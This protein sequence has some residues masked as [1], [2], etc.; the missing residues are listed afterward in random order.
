M[1]RD[2]LTYGA[3]RVHPVEWN[4][5]EVAGLLAAYCLEH[6]LLPRA[7][8]NQPHELVAFQAVLRREGIELAWPSLKPL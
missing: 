4:V 3:Y 7:V 2:S 5:G 6:D 8:R 1:R